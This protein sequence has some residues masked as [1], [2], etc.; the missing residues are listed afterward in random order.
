[1]KRFEPR[2]HRFVA[3][4][5]HYKSVKTRFKTEHFSSFYGHI[6]ILG[7]GQ[8]FIFFYKS[9]FLRI[10]FLV[11]GTVSLRGPLCEKLCCNM[12]IRLHCTIQFLYYT[13]YNFCL[14]V[15]LAYAFLRPLRPRPFQAQSCRVYGFDRD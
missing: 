10:F 8:I 2:F 14:F 15:F 5:L 4:D 3:A 6:L 11:G 7:C 9:Y 1:M 13:I 12:R